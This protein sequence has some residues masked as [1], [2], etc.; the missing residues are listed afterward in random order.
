MGAAEE[1]CSQGSQSGSLDLIKVVP[2]KCLE[3]R[4]CSVGQSYY[5]AP[6]HL[7]NSDNTVLLSDLGSVSSSQNLEGHAVGLLITVLVP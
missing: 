6:H 4:V 7:S 3:N 2:E 1:K 5:I